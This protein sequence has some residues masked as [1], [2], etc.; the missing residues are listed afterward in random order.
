MANPRVSAS[1]IVTLTIEVEAYSSWSA[2]CPVDQIHRQASQEVVSRITRA[3]R[4]GKCGKT[5][6][7]GNPVV[8]AVIATEH[9][10]D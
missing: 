5:R 9:S 7:L 10:Q 8:R 2:G 4:D 3:L 6:L 1:A